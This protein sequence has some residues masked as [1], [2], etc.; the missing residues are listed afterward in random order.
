M[1]SVTIIRL[2]SEVH[3]C[4]V[5]ARLTWLSEFASS[6]FSGAAWECKLLRSPL[7]G[8]YFGFWSVLIK[9][10]FLF[11]QYMSP[12]LECAKETLWQGGRAGGSEMHLRFM[13]QV[14]PEMFFWHDMF[15]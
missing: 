10:N 9:M 8:F 4:Q 1:P 5:G 13:A 15:N 2:F 7:Q 11:L 3:S 12:V 14:K 6:R